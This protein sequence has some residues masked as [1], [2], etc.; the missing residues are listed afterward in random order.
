MQHNNKKSYDAST[1]KL[2]EL[3]PSYIS[4]LNMSSTFWRRQHETVGQHC[5]WPTLFVVTHGH[6]C[7]YAIAHS[8]QMQTVCTSL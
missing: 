4:D 8:S 2:R 3:D 5:I 7:P 6:F 1:P